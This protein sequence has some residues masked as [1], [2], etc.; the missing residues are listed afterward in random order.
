MLPFCVLKPLSK[1]MFAVDEVERK[2][3]RDILANDFCLI[4]M[5]ENTVK[6]LVLTDLDLG[7]IWINY[8]ENPW[9]CIAGVAIT[10]HRK[11][12]FNKQNL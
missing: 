11:W 10:R 3:E 8:I 6:F 5:Q 4:L 12:V 7:D 9:K 2:K 1:F